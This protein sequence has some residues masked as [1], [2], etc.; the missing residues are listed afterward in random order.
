MSRCIL[1][2]TFD[3]HATITTVAAILCHGINIGSL[4]F[5]ARLYAENS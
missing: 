4:L 3:A 5:D 1:G 2:S